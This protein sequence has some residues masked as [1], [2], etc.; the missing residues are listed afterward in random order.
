MYKYTFP[1]H[2]KIYI[3]CAFAQ[4]NVQYIVFTFECTDIFVGF[5]GKCT[6]VLYKI[7]QVC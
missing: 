2:G 4:E 6:C 5:T 1:A 7:K 3:L